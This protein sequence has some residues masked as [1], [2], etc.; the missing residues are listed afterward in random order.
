LKTGT[1]TPVS[2]LISRFFGLI[3]GVA[4]DV[5]KPFIELH[6][7]YRPIMGLLVFA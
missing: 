3:R 7:F 5:D 4:Q 1:T 6:F 2:N